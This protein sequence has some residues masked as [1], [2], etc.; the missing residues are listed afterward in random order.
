MNDWEEVPRQWAEPFYLRG[1]TVATGNGRILGHG[2]MRY[3]VECD[4][5]ES[6][7]ISTEE[8]VARS[9]LMWSIR[10]IRG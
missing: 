3:N 10:H 4:Q 7:T 8:W 9:K 6:L 2:Y 1:T 5:W